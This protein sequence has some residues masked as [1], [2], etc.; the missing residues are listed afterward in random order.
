MT[1]FKRPGIYRRRIQ[2]VTGPGFAWA[3]IEDD[4]HC[5]RVGVVHDG[6]RVLSVGC[7]PIRVPWNLC[8]TAKD[9]LMRLAGMPLSGDALDARH[10][11]PA[12]QQ[13]T[14]MFDTASIAIAHAARGI[15]RRRYDVSVECYAINGPSHIEMRIDDDPYLATTIENEAFIKPEDWKGVTTR[16]LYE[17]ARQRSVDIDYLEAMWILR[18]AIHISNNRIVNLDE[19]E[20][21][22]EVSPGMGACF[23]Y[24]PGVADRARRVINS[25]LDFTDNTSEMLGWASV[26]G[27]PDTPTAPSTEH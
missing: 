3:L 25:T 14:H 4:P 19:N 22:I 10:F 18:R 15:E 11:T 26:A 7:D 5:Y 20:F 24:Q 9:N 23:V 27:I 8:A 1:Q 21:A 17:W 13:C 16:N 2:T 12:A 6:A